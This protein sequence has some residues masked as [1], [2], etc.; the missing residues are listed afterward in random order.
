M[1][2]TT[3]RNFTQFNAARTQSKKPGVEGNEQKGWFVSKP[4]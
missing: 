2:A 4:C 1:K 3:I